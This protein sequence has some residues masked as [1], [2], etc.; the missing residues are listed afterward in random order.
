MLV[1]V[2]ERTREIGL[3]K[4]ARR[5]GAPGRRAS[6]SS[7]R[8]SSR[9]PAA[10]S[11]S[12]RPSA[13]TAA[14]PRPLPELPGAAAVWAVGAALVVSLS[15]GLL[16]GAL[17]A[18]RA[19]RLDPVAALREAMRPPGR[20]RSLRL[21]WGA[22]AAH[23]LRSALTMLGIVIGIASVILLTSLGEGTRRYIVAE[24]TQFGTNIMAINTGQ[25]HDDR[26]AGRRS[27]ARSASSRS[28]TPRRSRACRGVESVVPVAYRHG[29]RRGRRAR[30]AASFVYGVTSDVPRGL[31]VRRPAGPLPARGRP[32]PGAPLAVL[33]PKLKRELFGE[34]QRA[35]RARA[36]RRPALPRH[37][38]HGAQGP[39]ARL[40]HRR[41]GLHPGRERAE[42]LQPA[43][44]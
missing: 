25:D 12:P 5:A 11:G 37:R 20:G 30:R 44:S 41:H 1:S 43:T 13:G 18:R 2:S 16:F 27:A 14:A 7:R 31:E 40:R 34:A 10:S 8:R 24:F 35:R 19:A 28:R 38:R 26:H 22:V 17:P 32:A 21:A 36:H 6:S 42:P 4:A 9:P 15:V 39:D 3:L 23:R 33:G 29:A